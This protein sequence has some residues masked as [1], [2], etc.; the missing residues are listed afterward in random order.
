M[1]RKVVDM[2]DAD[3]ELALESVLNEILKV[4]ISFSVLRINAKTRTV[5]IGKLE[6]QV[7]A[8]VKLRRVLGEHFVSDL[9]WVACVVAELAVEPSNRLIPALDKQLHVRRLWMRGDG[10]FVDL[11]PARAG[12]DEVS[13]LW[14]YHLFNEV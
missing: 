8:F 11:D 3:P 6:C 2:D 10:R 5:S 4:S 9:G 14:A 12:I 13:D 7:A 1:S